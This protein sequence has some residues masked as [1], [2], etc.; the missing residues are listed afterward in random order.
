MKRELHDI[1]K[2]H[3]VRDRGISTA[4]VQTGTEPILREQFVS[5]ETKPHP[6]GITH[7][8]DDLFAITSAGSL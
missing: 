1:K 3:A 6:H 8:A 7:T 5:A 4:P 2:R